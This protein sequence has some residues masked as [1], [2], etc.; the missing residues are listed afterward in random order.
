MTHTSTV[1]LAL[2]LSLLSFESAQAS[3]LGPRAQQMLERIFEIHDLD[4]DGR[5]TQAELSTVREQR[6]S[7]ADRNEDGRLDSDEFEAWRESVSPGNA[8]RMRGRGGERFDSLDADSDGAISLDEFNAVGSPMLERADLDGD[9]V[10][11]R[12]ELESSFARMR[13]RLPRN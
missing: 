13:S 9:G 5:I 8:R 11:T 10:I 3:E 4:E 1:I 2:S 7:R 6:F 12:T